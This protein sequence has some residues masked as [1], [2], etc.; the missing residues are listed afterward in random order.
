MKVYV[1]TSGE[2]SDYHICAVAL[3]DKK[4]KILKEKFDHDDYT[5]ATIEEYDT[6]EYEGIRS[7]KS[8]YRVFFNKSG[9]CDEIMNCCKE[10]LNCYHLS[11]CKEEP[12]YIQHTGRCIVYVLANCKEAAIKIAAERRAKYLAEKMGL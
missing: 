6:E 1:I 12:K 5:G 3:D 4:A 10:G 8:V 9:D 11:W 7:G 2:Y